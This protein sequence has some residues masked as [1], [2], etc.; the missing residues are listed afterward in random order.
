M[1]SPGLR[2]ASGRGCPA[3]PGL[4]R[5]ARD[6]KFQL[7]G[8]LE[9][10]AARRN[11]SDT[12]SSPEGHARAPLRGTERATRWRPAHSKP[13]RSLPADITS[14]GDLSWSKAV[15]EA[16]VDVCRFNAA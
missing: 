3:Q 12:R 4:R 14:H 10:P 1:R 11:V 16:K 5:P 15:F 7:R 8:N 6:P 2:R 9:T 13:K